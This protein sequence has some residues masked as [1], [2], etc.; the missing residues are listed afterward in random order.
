MLLRQDSPALGMERVK[1][2]RNPFRPI[3]VYRAKRLVS[4]ESISGNIFL[5]VVGA[6][7]VIV[8]GITTM[9]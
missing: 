4:Y 7:F 8:A 6:A 3:T 2:M 9:S 1:M 5:R